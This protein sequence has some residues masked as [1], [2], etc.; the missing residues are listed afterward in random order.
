MQAKVRQQTVVS[1]TASTQVPFKN[2]ATALNGHPLPHLLDCVS[3]TLS[4]G[5][6]LFSPA[7]SRSSNQEERARR[8]RDHA[9]VFWE[10][11][12]QFDQQTW[13]AEVRA[14][15]N[16]PTKVREADAAIESGKAFIC[17]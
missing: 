14:I 6:S 5:S 13:D 7:Q 2:L 12:D 16:S 8:E 1:P 11:R 15:S 4:N 9:G 17:F 3:S 10:S